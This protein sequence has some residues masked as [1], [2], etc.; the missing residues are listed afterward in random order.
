[1]KTVGLCFYIRRKYCVTSLLLLCSFVTTVHLSFSDVCR[2]S[3]SL[4]LASLA[5]MA[6]V[7]TWARSDSSAACSAGPCD[8]TFLS[9]KWLMKSFKPSRS[10]PSLGIP[11]ILEDEKQWGTLIFGGSHGTKWQRGVD[12]KDTGFET[13]VNYFFKICYLMVQFVIST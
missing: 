12:L 6:L 3:Y 5:S 1:M 7:A 4:S 11:E 10:I 2:Q 13:W 8:W 9:R